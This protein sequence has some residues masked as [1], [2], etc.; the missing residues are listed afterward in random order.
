MS[1]NTAELQG[2]VKWFSNDKGYGFITDENNQDFYFSIRDVIG[3]SIPLV[4]SKV[5]FLSHQNEKRRRAKSVNIKELI[6]DQTPY[7]ICTRC[8]KK[9][10]QQWRVETLAFMALQQTEYEWQR[11]I[12]VL[13]KISMEFLMAQRTSFEEI[14]TFYQQ[15]VA[16][17]NQLIGSPP[18]EIPQI[19]QRA[20]NL[21]RLMHCIVFNYRNTLEW[22]HKNKISVYFLPL[23]ISTDQF[24]RQLAK[25]CQYFD[26][27]QAEY[28]DSGRRVFHALCQSIS[29]TQRACEQRIARLLSP[30]E[31]SSVS[32]LLS[33][34]EN[35][36]E[37]PPIPVAMS[38]LSLPASTAVINLPPLD[39]KHRT[40]F[41]A[42]L[43]HKKRKRG[44]SMQP[45]HDP[46][47][48]TACWLRLQFSSLSISRDTPMI[49]T[50]SDSEKSSLIIP[51]TVIN[52]A[53]TE[54]EK[55]RQRQL[56][57]NSSANSSA[58]ASTSSLIWWWE[59]KQWIVRSAPILEGFR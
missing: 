38:P 12:S 3:Q 33:S 50:T 39:D 45:L 11:D 17:K 1:D 30:F 40:I 51:S 14:K 8:N 53:A 34:P 18:G 23:L 6:N 44:A 37:P 9:M 41:S 54:L 56:A 59:S 19:M 43:T 36:C 32:L 29:Q 20:G 4:G 27:A 10:V 46:A 7:V 2:K 42:T 48:S 57:L 5:S 24:E 22:I 26:Q 47:T 21:I 55:W 28:A 25:T 15:L 16:W 52:L 58:S 49:S 35:F 31:S 13:F